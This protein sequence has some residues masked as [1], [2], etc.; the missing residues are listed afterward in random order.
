MRPY[1]LNTEISYFPFP[2]ILPNRNRDNRN[3]LTTKFTTTHHK[4]PVIISV[5]HL[6]PALLRRPKIAS[7]VSGNYL[8]RGFVFGQCGQTKFDKV[9]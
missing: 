7:V 4:Y 5:R 3:H 8:L 2:D 1:F 6:K 9:K